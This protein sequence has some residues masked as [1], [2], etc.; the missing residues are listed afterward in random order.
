MPAKKATEY[1]IVNR[2]SGKALQAAGTENGLVVEQAEI[3]R[4]SLQVWSMVDSGDSVKIVNKASGKLLDVMAGGTVNG[5]W[6]QIWEDAGGESQLWKTEAVTS[7]YQKL[8]HVMS[9]KVL[10]I[11]DLSDE[12]GTPA[13]LWEDVGGENQQWKLVPAQE[14]PATKTVQKTAAKKPAP[15][16]AVTAVKAEA[17]VKVEVPAK[18]E[19][20]V[21][22]E[23]PIK[24]EAPKK[25][26][27][28][29]KASPKRAPKKA[30]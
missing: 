9:G 20:P 1:L 6:A 30:K 14:K 24:V 21:K 8:V 29:Q 3:T 28:S 19:A 23:A 12:S 5:T 18:T 13:Q 26:V 22:A 16:E 17:P 10:D 2:R 25:D 7:T 15:A 4:D 11:V 27:P